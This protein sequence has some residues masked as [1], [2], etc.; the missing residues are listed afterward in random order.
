MEQRT[1]RFRGE[2]GRITILVCGLLVVLVAVIGVTASAAYVTA[3]QRKLLGVTD[4]A[5]AAAADRIVGQEG[6]SPAEVTEPSK[7]LRIDARAVRGAVTDY[8]TELGGVDGL[9]GVTV[10]D[11]RVEPDGTTARV[12][13]QARIGAPWAGALIGGSSDVVATAWVRIALDR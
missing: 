11:V 8:L 10:A 13:L 2:S 5:A 7:A 6:V 12:R 1:S 4:A 3:Q 9:D